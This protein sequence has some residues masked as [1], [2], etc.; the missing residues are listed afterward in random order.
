MIKKSLLL[1]ICL[2]TVAFSY[3]QKRIYFCEDYT[4]TG[5]PV[6]TSSVWNI[7][8]SGGMVYFLYQNDGANITAGSLNIY[9]DK[10]TGKEY[11]EYSTNNLIPDKYKSWVIYDYKFT[12]AGEYKVTFMDGTKSLATEYVTIQIKEGEVASAKTEGTKLTSDY[13]TEAKIIFCESVDDKGFAKTPSSVFN[14]SASAG[15]YIYVLVDHLKPL[16]TSEIIVDVWKGDGYKE[17]VETVRFEVKEN[18]EWSDFKYTFYKDGKYKFSIY[19]KDEVFI[20]TGYV[21]IS[22][23]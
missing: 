11:K 15:G 23:N 2:L 14:I 12:E 4:A 6:K 3:S 17:F 9:V 8:S 19:N 13:Y 20:Q 21:S 1:L 16:K 10:L 18:W 22:Y 7:K 5:E